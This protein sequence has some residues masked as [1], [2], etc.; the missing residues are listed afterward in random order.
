MCMGCFE[1][2]E[3]SNTAVPAPGDMGREPGFTL[4][5]LFCREGKLGPEERRGFLFNRNA[6]SPGRGC[7]TP[8]LPTPG[9]PVGRS[10]PTLL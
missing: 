1:T 6:Q 3:S 9:L 4:Y 7:A 8:P 5:G 2:S 10:V